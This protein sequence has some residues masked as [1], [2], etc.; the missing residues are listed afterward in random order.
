MKTDSQIKQDVL[1][2]LKWDAEID[3]SK[4]GIAVSSGAVTMTG[5]V[6]T[7]RQKMAALQA[8]K[9]VAGV[10][11]IVNNVDVKL[12][13]QYRATDEGLAE[14]IANVLRWNVSIPGQEIKAEVKN[15][16]VTVSGNIE[17]WYQRN[18]IMR[19]LEHV[20]GVVNVIDALTLKPRTSP[21]D[22]QK[23]IKDALL[24]HADI[25][26]AKI[27]VTYANGVVTLSGTVES[28][29]EL[30]RV[31]GAAWAAPGVTSVIDNL[32]VAA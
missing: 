14:R 31:E 27:G 9:R 20:S 32:R 17:W 2:E 13:S 1:S 3:E 30:D 10:L 29:E 21:A 15:G 4:V 24:R 28:V 16:I 23:K 7:Y 22:V 11:A 25:E 26:A 12:E 19:N 5:H 18:N 8:T 6:P